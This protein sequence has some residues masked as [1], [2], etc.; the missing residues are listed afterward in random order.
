VDS[1]NLR[2]NPANCRRSVGNALKQAVFAY[3]ESAGP[4]PLVEQNARSRDDGI[5]QCMSRPCSGRDGKGEDTN[6]FVQIDACRT[7][8]SI[9]PADRPAAPSRH[10]DPTWHRRQSERNFHPYGW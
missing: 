8:A 2:A 7:D 10:V 4:E 5:A 9:A 3:A 6:I 1:G